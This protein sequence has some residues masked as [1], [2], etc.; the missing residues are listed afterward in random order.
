MNVK[1]KYLNKKISKTSTNLILFVNDSFNTN[2]LK[3]NLNR[4]ELSYINDLLKKRSQKKYTN[5]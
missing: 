4:N 2:N 5:F 1:L 3:N